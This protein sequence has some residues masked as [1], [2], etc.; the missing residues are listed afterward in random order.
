MSTMRTANLMGVL[1]GAVGDR[2]EQRRKAHP[3]E[4]DSSLAAL[5]LLSGFEGCSNLELSQAMKLS[6]PA[7]V[8][9]VDKLEAAGWVEGRPGEDRRSVSL[10]L[11]ASGRKRVRQI[12][13][14]RGTALAKIVDRLSEQQRRNLDDIAQTLLRSMTTSGLEAAYICRLCD[15]GACPPQ[16]CP[17]H[18]AAIEAE[19][20][21]ANSAA[22]RSSGH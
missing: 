22:F 15:D 14:E 6:H 5:N 13:R 9:L 19:S 18:Q 16:T 17:V 4:T 3:N 21:A 10:W 8:R 12:A 7:T 1:A 20:K 11:T 2:L